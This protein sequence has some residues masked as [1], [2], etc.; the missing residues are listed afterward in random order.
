MRAVPPDVRGRAIGVAASGLI[1]VQGL[2]MLLTGWAAEIWG[3]RAAVA[4]CGVVGFALAVGLVAG[5]TPAAVSPEDE[6]LP[7]GT[8]RASG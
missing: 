3:A 4:V 1:G 7:V 6:H 8:V 2:A 5:D